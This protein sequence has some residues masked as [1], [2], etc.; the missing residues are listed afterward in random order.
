MHRLTD[1]DLEKISG[2]LILGHT[3]LVFFPNAVPLCPSRVLLMIHCSN[4]LGLKA[5]ARHPFSFVGS[6]IVL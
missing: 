2:K 4:E 6:R 3:D 5:V 1:L